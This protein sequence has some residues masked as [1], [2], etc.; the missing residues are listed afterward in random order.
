MIE[1]NISNWFRSNED[2]AELCSMIVPMCIYCVTHASYFGVKVISQVIRLAE[3]VL[4][5]SLVSEWG[6]MKERM[7]ERGSENELDRSESERV[8]WVRVRVRE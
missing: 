6:L 8:S 7:S 2:G 4:I 1:K 3:I 5:V